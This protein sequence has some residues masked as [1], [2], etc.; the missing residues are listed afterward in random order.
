[1]E[2]LKDIRRRIASARGTRKMTKAMKLVATAKLRVAQK[3]AQDGRHYAVSIRDTIARVS[4]HLG[5]R[6][7]LMWRRPEQI[8]CIDTVIIT[9]DRGFCGG[10]NEILLRAL[11]EGIQEH[12]AHNIGV[13]LYAIGAKGFRYLKNRG[14]DVEEVPRG[15]DG[16]V[17][18]WVVERMI[19]RF[20][21]H[22]SAGGYVGFNRFIKV[23][24]QEPT[25]WNLLPLYKFGVEKVRHMEYLYE[26]E[27]IAT[28]NYICVEMLASTIRQSLL[29][30]R[31]AEL[32]ARMISMDNATRNADDM[33]AHLTVQYNKARQEAITSELMDIVGGAE[34]LR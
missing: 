9:S 3:A 22:S 14:Y 4:Q 18:H 21:S 10:F 25:F 27:R 29:E 24:D 32:A 7:P 1:M 15:G 17:T 13:K 2:S 19:E 5:P 11:E 6:A 20:C 12:V 16:D 28:L 23:T 8:N 34:A 33:I 26:P 31:A 30:S